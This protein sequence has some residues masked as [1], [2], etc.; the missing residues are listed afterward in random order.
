[1]KNLHFMDVVIGATGG[2]V[3]FC[4]GLNRGEAGLLGVALW[5]AAMGLGYLIRARKGA[6]QH[7]HQVRDPVRND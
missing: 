3:G 2:L 5:L 4:L 6:G 1:M 7:K